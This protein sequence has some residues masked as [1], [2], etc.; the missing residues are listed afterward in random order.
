MTDKFDEIIKSYEQLINNDNKII[1]SSLNTCKECEI[2][3]INTDENTLTCPYCG[4]TEYY[5]YDVNPKNPIVLYKRLIHFNNTLRTLKGE[6][7]PKLN[8]EIINKIKK[9]KL[10]NMNVLLKKNKL[11]NYKPYILKQYFGINPIRL[12]QIIINQLILKLNKFEKK[13]N[14]FKSNRKNFI[15]YYLLIKIFLSELGYTKLSEQIEINKSK[16]T[17]DDHIKLYYQIINS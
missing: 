13:F 1:I 14:N 9:T 17:I 10:E 4:I 5:L 16:H 15:N 2:D 7:Y 3:L 8:I 12:N 6:L 11:I